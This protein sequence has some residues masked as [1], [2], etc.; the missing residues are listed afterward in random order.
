MTD[1]LPALLAFA[2]AGSFTPGPNNMMLTAS[3]ATFGFRRSLPHIAGVSLGFPVM[4]LAVGL[5]LGT[6]FTAYPVVHH[7]LKWVGAAYLAWLAWHVATARRGTAAEGGSRP[8]TFVQAAA[9]QWVNPKAW[10]MGVGALATFTSPDASALGSS[11]VVAEVMVV[12]LVFFAVAVLS[13]ATW[14]AFG[15]GIGRFLSSDRRLRVFNLTMGALL[16][17]SIIPALV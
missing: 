9:F 1:I 14:T 8:L 6:V 2:F 4:V 12:A 3:G 15:T 17:L 16:L 13:T 7:V 10:M 5:G 11:R